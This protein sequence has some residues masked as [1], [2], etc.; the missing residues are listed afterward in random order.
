[1]SS[2]VTSPSNRPY[3]ST[4]MAMCIL[5][6]WNSRRSAPAGLDLGMKYGSRM[7]SP[8]EEGEPPEEKSHPRRSLP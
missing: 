3:S 6:L 8:T 2:M 5:F 4:T 7:H 1:M